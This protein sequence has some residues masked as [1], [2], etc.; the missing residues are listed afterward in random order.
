MRYK[1]HDLFF[2][3]WR[4]VP[5]S[6][7]VL[8]PNKLAV[9]IE[10]HPTVGVSHFK[11]ERG[12]VVEVRQV[13]GRER[14]SQRVVWP[15]S[16]ASGG[17]RR[18]QLFGEIVRRDFAGVFPHWQQPVAQIRLDFHES[19]PCRLALLRRDLDQVGIEVNV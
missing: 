10:D 12:R 18:V 1:L 3:R 19:S 16:Y 11:S 7:R 5:V 14:V 4:D 9:V 15:I 13:V 8:W 6:L 2:C 17:A